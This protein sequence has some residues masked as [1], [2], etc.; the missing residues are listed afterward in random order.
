VSRP[1]DR[2]RD[3]TGLPAREVVCIAADQ[4][5]RGKPDPAGYERAELAG[6]HAFVRHL[7]GGPAL[8]AR[9]IA[10]GRYPRAP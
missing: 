10:D 4:V 1:G 3:R 6:A 8:A 2:R 9:L 5:T 7:H